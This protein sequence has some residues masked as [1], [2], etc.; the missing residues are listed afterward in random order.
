MATTKTL[1]DEIRDLK[2]R[3]ILLTRAIKL[4]L[5]QQ[6]AHSRPVGEQVSTELL[7]HYKTLVMLLGG[8]SQKDRDIPELDKPTQIHLFE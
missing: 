6:I 5:G 7:G 3:N 4:L 1:Q 2:R 8:Y